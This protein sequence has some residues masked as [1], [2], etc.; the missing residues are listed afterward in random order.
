MNE[1]PLQVCGVNGLLA[2]KIF[3]SNTGPVDL[4]P[5]GRSV[6]SMTY[7][8]HGLQQMA[9]QL[10]GTA[11]IPSGE[12]E[13][14]AMRGYVPQYDF[15]AHLIY[16]GLADGQLKWVGL[17]DRGAGC[18]DDVVLGLQ[19]RIVGYQIKTQTNPEAF[20]L[21]SL[22]FGAEKLAKKLYHAWKQLKLDKPGARVQVAY[23]TRDFPRLNDTL[24]P[25]DGDG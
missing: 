22:L 19:D 4:R 1:Q 10:E 11:R 17:A 2:D 15:A 18:F 13:R 8:R 3:L 9:K 25:H 23:L 7:Q 5:R 24:G 14:R 21:Q 16:E 20:G 12:G 6:R